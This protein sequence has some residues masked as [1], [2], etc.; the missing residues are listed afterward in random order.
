MPALLQRLSDM[1]WAPRRTLLAQA[2]RPLSWLYRLMLVLRRQGAP[3]RLPVPVLVVGNLVAGGTGKTPVV[4]ALVQALR[5]AGWQPGVISR[6]HGRRVSGVQAVAPQAE[7]AA[8]GDEPLLIA[9][10]SQAPVFVGRDRVAAGRALLA[11][12]PEVKVIVSDDG[13]QHQ[14]LHHDA[15]IVVWDS[16]GA[17]NGL[18]LPSGPLREP[19]PRALPA[20]HHA[21]YVQATSPSTALPG[22]CVAVGADRAVPLAAWWAGNAA[23]AVP[24]K[25]LRGRPL[26]ALAGLGN[27]EKFFATLRGVG[28]EIIPCPQPDHAPYTAV[29]WPPGTAEVITT[30]KDAV[31]LRP[32]AVGATRVWVLPL[33]LD[34]PPALLAALLSHLRR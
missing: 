21:L 4:I 32:Q 24:L 2:L 28:L 25:A 27:P 31:K 19:L 14:A 8:V 18:L 9:R 13:L 20:H 15:A 6:G 33:D 1:A 10:R 17:G 22:P 11:A 7:A 26:L 23:A 29:P 30:E 16:R 3:T 5:A 34:L 12:H